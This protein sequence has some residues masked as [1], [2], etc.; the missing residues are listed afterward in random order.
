[1]VPETFE[2]INIL[3]NFGLLIEISDDYS[4]LSIFDN[5]DTFDFI[6]YCQF[7]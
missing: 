2:S 7:S 1:M 6:M 4:F 3:S 5:R